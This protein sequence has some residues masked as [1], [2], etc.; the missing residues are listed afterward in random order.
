MHEDAPV[1]Y[2]TRESEQPLRYFSMEAKGVR[3]VEHW[4]V[5]LVGPDLDMTHPAIEPTVL[6]HRTQPTMLRI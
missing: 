5:P 3:S 4:V 6:L 2:V 1:A